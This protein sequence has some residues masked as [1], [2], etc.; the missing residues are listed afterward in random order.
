MVLDKD[1]EDSWVGWVEM[2]PVLGSSS[3]GGSGN[4]GERTSGNSDA[5]E[6]SRYGRE[7]GVVKAGEKGTRLQV[8]LRFAPMAQ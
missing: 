3:D 7:D 1:R 6:R 5:N 8:E 4:V 2:D